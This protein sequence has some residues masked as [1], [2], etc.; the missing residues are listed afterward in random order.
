MEAFSSPFPL[1]FVLHTRV[2]IRQPSPRTT[3]PAGMSAV[4]KRTVGTRL[5]L[6][7]IGG[8]KKERGIHIQVCFFGH[9]LGNHSNQNNN[10]GNHSQTKYLVTKTP[11]RTS[12]RDQGKPRVECTS[13]ADLV[14]NC[15]T[16]GV[17]ILPP[18]PPPFNF[19][20][21]SSIPLGPLRRPRATFCIHVYS[22]PS[23][24]PRGG[25]Y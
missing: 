13:L 11:M 5:D 22:P 1:F 14:A 24:S 4:D 25:Y 3:R 18:P 16:T 6:K 10:L 2:W 20:E 15:F 17:P 19:P 12:F 8:E 9:C 23:R 7:Y 21:P